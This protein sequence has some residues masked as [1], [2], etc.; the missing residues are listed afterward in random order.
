MFYSGHFAHG[1]GLN[2]KRRCAE[3][4][5]ADEP[6]RLAEPDRFD[7]NLGE[8]QMK[9]KFLS[10]SLIVSA[11]LIGCSSLRTG[12]IQEVDCN[13]VATCRVQV[14]VK[15][16]G[17]LCNASVDFDRVIGKRNGEI[18]WEISNQT[19]QT[20]AFDRSNGIVFPTDTN[21]N[22]DCHVEASGGRFS[23]KNRG[24]RGEYK[25]TVNLVGSSAVRPLD[26]W[27][28]NN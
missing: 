15:C 12:G 3:A 4:A 5:I 27:V 6:M 18:V 24:D 16:F 17:V 8:A 26:P 13:N 11:V 19:G 7:Q 22:F 2:K 21:R 14:S 20:Y 28:V 23:C 9:R 25:Y 10:C 1:V